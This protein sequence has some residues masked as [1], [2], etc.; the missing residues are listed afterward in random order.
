MINSSN[1]YNKPDTKK[2]DSEPDIIN[3]KPDTKKKDSKKK[4]TKK[5]IL[6]RK[7]VKRK[8]NRILVR[9]KIM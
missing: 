7:T 8:I 3:D 9:K 6:K 2:K 1:V 5:K 4:D